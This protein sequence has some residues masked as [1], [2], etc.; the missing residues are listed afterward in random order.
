LQEKLVKGTCIF[1]PSNHNQQWAALLKIMRT[2]LRSLLEAC[3]TPSIA[4]HA[5][6]VALL[7][8]LASELY[9][10]LQNVP[11][12]DVAEGSAQR[13]GRHSH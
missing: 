1:L 2:R 5:L 11:G 6:Y 13:D 3:T 12:A 8:Y 10:S 9:V 4:W 7:L